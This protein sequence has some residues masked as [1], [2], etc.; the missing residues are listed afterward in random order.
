LLHFSLPTDLVAQRLSYLERPNHELKD[1]LNFCF[2][3]VREESKHDVV[4]AKERD[5]QQ[6]G[7]G[8]PPV[9]KTNTSHNERGT[10]S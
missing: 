9:G 1:Q 3:I 4:N 2:E 5:Q 7:L 8:Q 6:G 10:R